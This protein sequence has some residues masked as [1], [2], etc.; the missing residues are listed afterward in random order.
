M[1][2]I[3]VVNLKGGSTK[4]TTTGHLGQAFHEAGM[5]VLGVDAD[6]ENESLQGW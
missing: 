5:R 1:L 2:V 4:T 6:G 3:A